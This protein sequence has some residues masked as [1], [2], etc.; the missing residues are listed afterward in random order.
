MN[1]PPIW[2]FSPTE[3]WFPSLSPQPTSHFSYCYVDTSLRAQTFSA[4]ESFHVLFWGSLLDCRSWVNVRS[5]RVGKCRGVNAPGTAHNAALD[6]GKWQLVKCPNCLLPDGLLWEMF[7]VP[8]RGLRGL[9]PGCPQQW[10]QWHLIT[11]AFSL[12][13]CIRSCTSIQLPGLP[14]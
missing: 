5:S 14:P 10:S 6:A 9:S 7:R 1:R 3:D 12:L 8:R 4:E 2:G 11:L 13:P